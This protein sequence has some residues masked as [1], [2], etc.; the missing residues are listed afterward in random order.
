[1]ERW[2]KELTDRRLRRGAFTSVPN[3]IEAMKLWVQHWNE[4]PKPFIWHKTAEEIIEK[5]R[6]GR[7]ALNQ[8]KTATH[9]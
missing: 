9:H 5:V 6:R 1:V 2:F 7:S 8:V 3:L 4:D